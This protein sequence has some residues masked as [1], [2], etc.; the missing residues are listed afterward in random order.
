MPLALRVPADLRLLLASS[1]TLGSKLAYVRMSV[2][3]LHAISGDSPT[4]HKQAHPH[5]TS[6]QQRP[7]QLNPSFTHL[8]NAQEEQQEQQPAGELGFIGRC[9]VG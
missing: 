8:H 6:K 7:P 4:T 1:A 3:L 2:M 5:R 9:S